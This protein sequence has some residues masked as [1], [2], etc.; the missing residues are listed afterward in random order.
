MITCHCITPPQSGLTLYLT[1]LDSLR[2]EESKGR[3]ADLL[4]SPGQRLV[5]D[6]GLGPEDGGHEAAGVAAHGVAYGHN[7]QGV[8][9]VHLMLHSSVRVNTSSLHW[10]VSMLRTTAFSR[11][12]ISHGITKYFL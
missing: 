7:I 6:G 8:T 5:E 9:D 4:L 11:S 12:A 10:V 2:E 1:I 3:E